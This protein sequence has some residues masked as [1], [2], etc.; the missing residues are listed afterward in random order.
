[1][2]TRLLDALPPP[3]AWLDGLA[4]LTARAALGAVSRLHGFVAAQGRGLHGMVDEVLSAAAHEFRT[5]LA[6]VRAEAQ[7]LLRERGTDARLANITRQV[8]RL[9]HLVQQ[10]LEAARLPFGP[11]PSAV[12]V[13]D[14]RQ[15]VAAVARR[16]ERSAPNHEV[17][18]SAQGRASIWVRADRERLA[19]ALANLVDNAIRFSPGGGVVEISLRALRGEARVAV[20]DEGVGIP[21]HRQRRLFELLYR[22]HAGTAHDYSG[23]G[24]GLAVTRHIVAGHG[25]AVRFTSAAGSGSTFEFSLPLAARGA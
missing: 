6:V 12:E 15:L 24:I 16:F 19:L 23:I 10:L 13:I 17:R 11:A 2:R 4:H 20:R 9:T 8:D 14:L 3:R 25:G 18:L 21:E 22:A 1:M 5:P 7:L